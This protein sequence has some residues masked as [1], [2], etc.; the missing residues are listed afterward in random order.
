MKKFKSFDK[1]IAYFTQKGFAQEFR[2]SFDTITAV[3]SKEQ[4]D[5]FD[6]DVISIEEINDEEDII[7]LFLLK[8]SKGTK[9]YMVN[10][11]GPDSDPVSIEIIDKLQLKNVSK[12]D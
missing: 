6:F 2:L 7:H 9:G 3:E 11:F 4:F 8:T 12:L 5:T 10:D 1:A